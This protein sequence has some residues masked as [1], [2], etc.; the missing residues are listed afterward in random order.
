MKKLAVKFFLSFCVLLINGYGTLQAHQSFSGHDTTQT[1]KDL[2][3]TGWFLAHQ[4]GIIFTRY[5]S[6]GTENA[7]NHFQLSPFENEENDDDELSSF[8]KRLE[9]SSQVTSILYATVISCLGSE[10][11]VPPFN[12]HFARVESDRYL[13]LQVFRI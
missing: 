12:Q 10:Q 1:T 6:F 7:K 2:I 9:T 3:N 5:A 4:N 13:V 8:R 11:R